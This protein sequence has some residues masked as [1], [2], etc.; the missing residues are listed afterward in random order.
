MESTNTPTENPGDKLA[1]NIVFWLIIVPIIS[2]AMV[3]YIAIL[4]KIYTGIWNWIN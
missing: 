4:Y 3:G 1:R 2:I